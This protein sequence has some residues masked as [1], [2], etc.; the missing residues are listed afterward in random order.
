MVN[1]HQN[2]L[3]PNH[4]TTEGCLMQAQLQVN[5]NKKG[6]KNGN[7]NEIVAGCSLQAVTVL[8]MLQNKNNGSAK[9]AVDLGPECILDLKANGGR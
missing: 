2:P 7:K 4:C 5:F 1:D 3:A 9:T 8:N 6:T